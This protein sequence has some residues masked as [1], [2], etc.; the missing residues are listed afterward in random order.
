MSL[1]GFLRYRVDKLKCG[2]PTE[3]EAARVATQPDI[4]VAAMWSAR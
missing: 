3:T 2:W 1:V 4:H